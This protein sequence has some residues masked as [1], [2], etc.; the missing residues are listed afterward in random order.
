MKKFLLAALFLV[1]LPVLAQESEFERGFNEG[2]KSCASPK[3]AWVCTL[4]CGYGA[5]Y[6]M[7]TGETKAAAILKIN[8]ECLQFAVAQDGPK[9]NCIQL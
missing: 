2:K 6:N 4:E 9:P 8:Y 5:P 3:E 7:G 1:S